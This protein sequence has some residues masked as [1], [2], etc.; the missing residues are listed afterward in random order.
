MTRPNDTL[1]TLQRDFCQWLRHDDAEIVPRL[2]LNQAHGL[3]VYQN[4]YRGQLVTC[5]AETLPQTLA[6]LGGEAFDAAA[7]THIEHTPPS[8]WT[9]DAY[10]AS[11]PAALAARYPDD[12]EVWELAGLEWQLSECFV[13]QDANALAPADLASIDWDAAQLQ[14]VPSTHILAFT[15]NAPDIWSALAAGDTPP[16]AAISDTAQAWLVWRQGFTCCFRALDAQERELLPNLAAGLAFTALCDQLV[17]QMGEEDG[18]AMAG[19]LLARWTGEAL[20]IL[21]ISAP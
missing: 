2:R 4:N 1:G 6:W 15:S 3:A 21:N 17:A 19:T 9:L 14:L 18:I 13:A 12:A 16:G 7:R 11:F 8:S 10:P 5:L 20:L